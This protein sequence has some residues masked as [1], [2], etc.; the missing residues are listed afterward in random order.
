MCPTTHVGRRSNVFTSKTICQQVPCTCN[1]H[2]I[3]HIDFKF[4]PR[5]VR[6]ITVVTLG[7]PQVFVGSC[8]YFGAC[9]DRIPR[10]RRGGGVYARATRRIFGRARCC[11]FTTATKVSGPRAFR[12]SDKERAETPPHSQPAN[13]YRGGARL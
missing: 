9:S 5:L 6:N 12:G 11:S 8:G 10:R 3:V 7:G 4:I 1:T 2:G 13:S